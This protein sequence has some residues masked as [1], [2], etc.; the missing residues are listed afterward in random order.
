M[1]HVLIVEDSKMFCSILSRKIQSELYFPTMI[2]SSYSEAEKVISKYK[3]IFFAAILDL[4][5]PDARGGE[6]VDFVLSHNIPSIILTGLLNDD[7]REKILSKDIVDYILKTKAHELEYVLRVVKRI[8]NN[9]NIKILVVD[10]SATS[11]SFIKKLL[12][13]NRFIVLEVDNGFKALDILDKHQDIKMAI[14]D[15]NMPKMDGAEL[16]SRIRKKYG[17]DELAIIGVSAHGS[18]AL[19]ARLLKSGANDFII[20]PFLTEEFHCRIMQ[21]IEYIEQMQLIRDMS[22]KD[23]LTEIPNRRYLFEVGEKLYENA[24]RNNI[25]L[26]A[27]MI[28]I[29]FFKRVNDVHGHHAGDIAL[30]HVASL[31]SRTMRKSDIVARFGG[32]E[33]CALAPNVNR[34]KALFLFER[35]RNAIEKSEIQLTDKTI[36][37]TASIGIVTNLE[38]S[39]EQMLNRAD[40]ALYKAKERGRNQVVIE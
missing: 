7:V 25:T 21:N 1:N 30:K 9:R 5:L 14:I 3:D 15:Y 8:Y 38:N 36:R 24:K 37:V 11:R 18:G 28:D 26:A 35:V 20:K 40:K 27:A 17:R 2:A 10:D 4:N 23:F 39:L 29:D 34:E 22:N 6:I 31:L 33:F 13:I 19:S 12:T 32:E 16:T